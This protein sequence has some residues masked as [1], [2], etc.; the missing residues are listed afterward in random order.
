M[1]KIINL[2]GQK[3]GKLTVIKQ[4]NAPEN[5]KNKKAIYWLCRCEC[6]R[7]RTVLSSNLKKEKGSRSCGYCGRDLTGQKFGKLTV[8][9]EAE[10]PKTYTSTG[11]YWLCRCECGREK[12]ISANSLRQGDT[13]S[14][15]CWQKEWQKYN[16]IQADKR[17]YKDLTGQRFG[18]LAVI[19]RVEKPKE[20]KYKNKLVYW[21]CKCDCGNEKIANGAFL[22]QG[23]T[24]SCGCWKEEQRKEFD[25][26]TGKIF[27]KLTV[28][29]RVEKPK[30]IKWDRPYYLCK[31]VCG[32]EQIMNGSSLTTG[33]KT[34]CGCEYKDTFIIPEGSKFGKWTVIKKVDRPDDISE[35][36]RNY[37]Y[38][39]KCDCGK[40]G[41]VQASS[42][43]KGN[44]NSCGCYYKEICRTRYSDPTG[45]NRTLSSRYNSYKTKAK[46]TNRFFDLTKEEFAEITSKDCFYCGKEPKK[47]EKKRK[48]S[49]GYIYNGID[50]I[51]NRRGYERDNIVPCCT[52]CNR[53]KLQSSVADFFEWVKRIYNY[54]VKN[55]E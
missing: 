39:C 43:R 17:W 29:K 22:R 19:K 14:C 47:I 51:D 49:D 55:T 25:D 27:G 16:P 13:K 54:S 7:E 1:G 28:I 46:S 18:R 3:F 40:E 31:C 53:A 8:I 15:G 10:R 42:L 5:I 38:L 12:V 48:S 33:E 26:L 2:T 44:S 4:E 9:E 32:K 21:L 30:H 6:G 52:Q 11:A 34:S 45:D 23:T 36:S 20:V 37:Y 24:Q 50:R 35:D 41:T